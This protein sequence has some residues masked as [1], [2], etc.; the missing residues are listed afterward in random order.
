MGDL[1]LMFM[2]GVMINL[3]VSGN[4][5]LGGVLFWVGG[6]VNFGKF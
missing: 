4:M 1:F 2:D 5:V 3:S 6:V